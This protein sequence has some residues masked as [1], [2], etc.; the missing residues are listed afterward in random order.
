MLTL[1]YA[2]IK[3]NVSPYAKKDI[4]NNTILCMSVK[5][6]IKQAYLSDKNIESV[7]ELLLNE[8]VSAKV[9]IQLLYNLYPVDVLASFLH[10]MMQYVVVQSDQKLNDPDFITNPKKTVVLLNYIAIKKTLTQILEQYNNYMQSKPPALSR[11]IPPPPPLTPSTSQLPIPP[12]I[13]PMA[14]VGNPQQ[15][16]VANYNYK[17]Q[18]FQQQQQQQSIVQRNPVLPVG[19]VSIDELFPP[20][21]P[22]PPKKKKVQKAISINKLPESELEIHDWW[23]NPDSMEDEEEYKDITVD[24]EPIQPSASV[25]VVKQPTVQQQQMEIV[26]NIPIPRV[27]P[28]NFINIYSVERNINDYPS[29]AHYV[30]LVNMKNIHAVFLHSID[31]EFEHNIVSEDNN[32]LY[33]SEDDEE[34]KQVV[35]PPMT[36]D[37]VQDILDFCSDLSNRLTENSNIYRYDVSCNRHTKRIK[38]KQYL[39]SGQ[40]KNKLHL[41]FEQTRRNCGDILGFGQ[42][43]DYRDESEYEAPFEHK[44]DNNINGQGCI[45]LLIPEISKEPCLRL[46]MTNGIQKFKHEFENHEMIRLFEEDDDVSIDTLTISFVD[47][48]GNPLSSMKGEHT[49]VLKY[50]YV[51]GGRLCSKATKA[52]E[53]TKTTHKPVHFTDSTNNNITTTTWVQCSPQETTSSMQQERQLHQQVVQSEEK[54]EK[55]VDSSFPNLTTITPRKKK[56]PPLDL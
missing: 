20:K 32:L 24:D 8:L 30:T 46:P 41:Y 23:K 55:S 47:S 53:A 2:G 56:L 15:V 35:L 19:S 34:M 48:L 14:T 22:K 31:I 3:F 39:Q 50:F 21:P 10:N 33:Y 9:N 42:D 13:L 12:R 25:E 40:G 29:P 28:W 4:V 5:Q 45:S 11:N 18:S 36:G 44:L 52:T 27:Y 26:Q 54:L 17:Q 37:N 43:R 51:P 38:I 16:H 7:N 49:I 6:R 1:T